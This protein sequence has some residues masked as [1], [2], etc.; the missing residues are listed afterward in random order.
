MAL[1][2]DLHA[3]AEASDSPDA[4]VA[5]ERAAIRVMEA[6]MGMEDN[7]EMKR[8]LG[9]TAAALRQSETE[10][11]SRPQKPA[12]DNVLFFGHEGDDVRRR[13]ALEGTTEVTTDDVREGREVERAAVALDDVDAETLAAWID[14]NS[15]VRGY[16]S[17]P[18]RLPKALLTR[19][20]RRVHC[21]S[22]DR[23]QRYAVAVAALDSAWPASKRG[24]KRCLDRD[25]LR[26]FVAQPDLTFDDV[27]DMVQTLVGRV[28]DEVKPGDSAA[29]VTSNES[30]TEQRLQRAFEKHTE[31]LLEQVRPSVTAM[32]AHRMAAFCRL[33]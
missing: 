1:A 7:A 4:A 23:D 18:W 25:M 3:S 16:S 31:R 33:V 15:G 27:R 20:P 13:A 21:P 8:S 32:D 5:Y 26:E 24:W 22:P 2:Q 6:V 14:R 30:E 9:D 28:L 29:T 19:F 10:L 17:R 12:S 11:Q